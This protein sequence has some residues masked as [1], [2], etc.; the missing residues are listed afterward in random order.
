M[1]F[2]ALAVAALVAGAGTSLAQDV[3]EGTLLLQQPAISKQHIV[4][5]Y[6]RDLWVVS[7]KGG[8]ARRLTSSSGA[9]FAP[10]ISPSGRYVAFTGEYDGNMDVYLM[11]I[12]GGVPKRLTWNPGFDIVRDWHPD[13]KRVLFVSD[14]AAGTRVTHLYQVGVGGGMPKALPIPR[15]A[16]AAWHKSGARLAYTPFNDAFRTWK[17]YRGG[18]TTPIWIYDVAT[19]EVQKVPHVNASDSFPCWIDDTVYFASDRDDRMNLW[20]FDSATGD[21][22]QVT[23]LKH[24]DIRHMSSCRDAVVFSQGGAL[25]VHEPASGKTTRLRIRVRSDGLAAVP[26]WQSVKGHVRSGSVA[27]NGKRV[28]FA[29]RGEIITVP[30]QHGHARNLTNSSGVHD[31]SPVWSPDGESIAWL[32][33]AS[34]EYQLMVRDHKGSAPAKSYRLHA[35]G[36]F[37]YDPVWS[38]D[39]KH[40]M[41][42]DKA[43][44]RSFVTL[45]TGKVRQVSRSKG[46]LGVVRV[47]GV[48]SPDSK[49]ICFGER[50]PRTAYDRLLL[51]EVATG[52]RHAL[53]DGFAD[54]GSP[55]FSA[56]GKLLFFVA[57]IDNGPRQFGL[58]MSASASRNWRSSIYAAVLK[59]DGKHPFGARSDEGFAKK[60]KADKKKAAPKAEIA[61][62]DAVAK[63]GS[64]EDGNAK[65][66]SEPPSIDVDGLDQRI[67]AVPVGSGRYN[68]LACTDKGLLY[69]DS[70]AGS[71]PVLK[72]FDLSKR[73][74]T[75][76][77][78]GISAFDLSADRKTLLVV[79]RGSFAVMNTMGKEKKT[80]PIDGVRVRV[81]PAKEWPQLL[82]EVWRIQRD[83]F[84]DRN[85]HGVDWNKMWDRW[86]PFV[87]HVRHRADL[88]VIIAELIGELCCG[89][90]YVSG[91]EFPKKPEGVGVGLLGADF[92]QENGRHKISR[93]YR[94]QNWNPSLR[95]PLTS[96]GV[97][98][99][100]GDYL[101][102]VDGREVT[103]RDN[104]FAFFENT[105]GRQVE[106]E[107]AGKADGSDKRSVVVEAISSERTLRQRSW[108]EACRK[109]VAEKSNGRVAYI[110]MPNTG[111]AGMAAF[112][113]DYYSQLDKEALIIDERFNGGGKVADYVI[114]VL[115][116]N[117]MCYWMNR[118]EWLGRTPFGTFEGPKVMIMNEMAGSGGDAMPWLFRQQGLGPLVGTRTWG[119]LVGISGYPPL[120]DGGRVT[121]A[122]F[123]V[124]DRDGNWAV[125][126]T[127]VPPDYEVVQY[128]KPVIEG[129]DPQLDKAIEL[130]LQGLAKRKNKKLP[131][132]KPPKKR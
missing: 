54:T 35:E 67:V 103:G 97:D 16:R 30:R 57:S 109:R 56:D 110:Y 98:A 41:Y 25:H 40:V 62:D 85:M 84:Y 93:I 87:A 21:L 50:N 60:E 119:G 116:R 99:N 39:G 127:G 105:A 71:A 90:E 128:P 61:A 88:D 92:V 102:S 45:E 72:S 47:D 1:R 108:I 112:D 44:G 53:T 100:V 13:G 24:F 77:G 64:T 121:A 117:V 118:E 123:G 78:S 26:R 96:P 28:V 15:A 20:S 6:A 83:Y 130:C 37:Y 7:R 32:S 124:M 126:N 2:S 3:S 74:E 27:P 36:S 111:S 79:S 94:G 49:W 9:E 68:Q 75:T 34:G 58:D 5:V 70:P 104:L 48:W 120:M 114:D 22:N 122:S 113:R 73:K 80:L 129:Q 125:E 101:M 38:P 43:G 55:A 86:S 107:L 31:R 82:R 63:K 10:R 81:D 131:G 12:E 91:G 14:R 42:L 106:L 59:K 11:L 52:K 23:K 89:H 18:R 46:S 66:K 19:H 4:F 132:Y 69:L 51:F 29:A 17:R 65:K 76:V 115:S 95:A 8:E 33:D